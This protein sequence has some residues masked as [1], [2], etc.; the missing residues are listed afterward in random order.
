MGFLVKKFDD[1]N[2][3]VSSQID[4]QQVSGVGSDPENIVCPGPIDDQNMIIVTTNDEASRTA[5]H[6]F[7]YYNTRSAC[8]K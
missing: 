7:L 4:I 1:F 3:V 5:M 8:V 2:Y 6:P